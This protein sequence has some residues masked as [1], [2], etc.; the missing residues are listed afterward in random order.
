LDKPLLSLHQASIKYRARILYS[1]RLRWT[2][3]RLPQLP[4]SGGSQAAPTVTT[5]GVVDVPL[6][7][8]YQLIIELFSTCII[9]LNVL[10]GETKVS[11]F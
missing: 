7:Q 5:G 4:A 10:A 2:T 1:M 6:Q 3:V 8:Y 9:T 11:F